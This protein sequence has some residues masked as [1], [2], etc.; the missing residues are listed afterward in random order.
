MDRAMNALVQYGIDCGLICP[1]D[2]VFA[3]NRVLEMM[4]LDAAD[5]QA[6]IDQRPLHEILEALTENAVQRGV[7]DDNQV[8]RDLFDTRLMGV[9]TPFPHEVRAKFNA[10]YQQSPDL[11]PAGG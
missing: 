8:A 3:L 1:E 7:C 5:T 4:Q 11:Q 6:A 10:L 9:L 2:R